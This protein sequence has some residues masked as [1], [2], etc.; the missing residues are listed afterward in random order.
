ANGQTQL[1]PAPGG[2]EAAG[3][4]EAVARYQDNSCRIV[5]LS[6]VTVCEANGN[7][8]EGSLS[9]SR[10]RPYEMALA[11]RI[12]LGSRQSSPT[13]NF[14]QAQGSDREVRPARD[15][16]HSCPDRSRTQAATPR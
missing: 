13:R 5:I 16:S 1:R 2:N 4:V 11:R 3:N 12:E 7:G 6:G 14:C 10:I 15:P 8:V 9:A